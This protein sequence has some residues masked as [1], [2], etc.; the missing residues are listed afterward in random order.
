MECLDQESPLNWI[1]LEEIFASLNNSDHLEKPH[2]SCFQ[3]ESCNGTLE[4]PA[5]LTLTRKVISY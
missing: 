2:Q 4:G 3:S 5:P 1:A